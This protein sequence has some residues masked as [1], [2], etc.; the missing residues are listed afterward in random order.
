MRKASF[1]EE[2]SELERYRVSKR[3][4]IR[5]ELSIEGLLLAELCRSHVLKT[6]D[7]EWPQSSRSHFL[8]YNFCE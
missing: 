1:D 8:G 4:V 3:I 5:Y 7:G 2:L 6:T